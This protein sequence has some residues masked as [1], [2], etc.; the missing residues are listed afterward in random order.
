MMTSGGVT[1]KINWRLW[2]LFNIAASKIAFENQLNLLSEH[3]D[4]T[5]YDADIVICWYAKDK[6]ADEDGW[7]DI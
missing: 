2:R 3:C 5:M 1:L 7:H 6:M 4:R